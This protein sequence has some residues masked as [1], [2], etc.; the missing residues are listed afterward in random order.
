MQCTG[1]L[2]RGSQAQL[3]WSRGGSSSEAASV[4]F[5]LL[6]DGQMHSY[7]A[8]LAGHPRWH[9]PITSLRFDP[10]D[11]AGVEVTIESIRLSP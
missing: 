4:H 7:T 9:G 1:A 5:P 6:A 11:A 10:C 3:F 8:V 2:P